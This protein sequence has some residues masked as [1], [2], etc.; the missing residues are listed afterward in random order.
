MNTPIV[1][2]IFNR[3]CVTAKVF[4]A[5]RK[6]RPKQ[7]LVIADG[8]RSDHKTDSE[9]CRAARAVIEKVDW[10]CEV[11]E[12]YSDINLG[13]KQRVSSGIN[14]VFSMV[15]EA[16]ILEDDCLPH[17]SFFRFCTELL[18]LYR[19]DERIMAISGNNLQ[20]G[21]N[22]TQYSYYFS[23]F[24]H[25]WGWATWKRA[26]Q[27]YDVE[28]RYFSQLKNTN[29]LNSILI[30]RRAK[31]CWE[32][33]FEEAYLGR[34]DTWDYAWTFA[35][36]LQNGLTI[37]PEANLVSNLGFGEDA[38][39]TKDVQSRYSNIAVKAVDFPLSHPPFMVCNWQADR[40]TQETLFRLGLWSWLRAELR[41]M[42][43]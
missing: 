34:I 38:T 5:I 24:N 2:I 19:N 11:L 10:D 20:F 15:N 7:L 16:I 40:F 30:N 22:T 4:E 31:K 6:V 26:W 41:E 18:D 8:P 13:C 29:W 17:P 43:Q 28:M 32:K 12:N 21:E 9:F 27:H 36:W 35:C 37:L 42:F 14:W 25:I 3:P 1:L 39:H 23:R 33:Q